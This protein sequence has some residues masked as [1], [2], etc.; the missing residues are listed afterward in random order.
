MKPEPKKSAV[1][2]ARAMTRRQWLAFRD[3]GV[4]PQYAD[5][6]DVSKLLRLQA[7]AYDWILNNVYADENLDDLPMDQLN[8]LA[9]NTYRKTYGRPETEKN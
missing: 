5:V 4:D 1:P 2:E 8:L 3:S 7:D 6:T 9:E